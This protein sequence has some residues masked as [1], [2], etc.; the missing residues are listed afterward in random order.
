MTI[1][2]C[3]HVGDQITCCQAFC[4]RHPGK[5]CVDT[6]VRFG[7]LLRHVTFEQAD[8]FEESTLCCE[9]CEDFEAV[10]DV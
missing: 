7:S 10:S 6:V 3:R 4:R 8:E 1:S 2:T 5:K 9:T